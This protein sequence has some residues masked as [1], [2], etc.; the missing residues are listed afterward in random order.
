M[1]KR[2]LWCGDIH[3]NFLDPPRIELFC[4]NVM[5]QKPDLVVITGDISEAPLLDVHLVLLAE[6]ITVPVYFVLG[7]HDYYHGSFAGVRLG[8]TRHTH[9]RLFYVSDLGCV[10]L[11]DKTML[12]GHDGWYDGGYS[13]WFKSRLIMADYQLINELKYL[14]PNL[15]YKKLQDKAGELVDHFNVVIPKAFETHE[16]LIALTHI[17]PFRE[18][19]LYGKKQSDDQWMPHFSSKLAGDVLLELADRFPGKNITLLCGH[20][21]SPAFYKPRV[22][23][24]CYTGAAD[25]S[26][27]VPE[28]SIQM[29]NVD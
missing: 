18:N 26:Y 3:L 16:N 6:C 13:N 14:P 11:T 10:P 9:P 27:K 25:H 1:S 24:E 20:T 22:N 29:I 21:H 5:A 8:M 15:L 19:C 7:N 4:Q 12:V 28:T 23:L 17:P 2:V